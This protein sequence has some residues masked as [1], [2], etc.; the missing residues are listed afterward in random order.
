MDYGNWTAEVSG[1][2]LWVKSGQVPAE[3]RDATDISPVRVRNSTSN[4]E[5]GIIVGQ[6]RR[7]APFL[8]HDHRWIPYGG[9]TRVMRLDRKALVDAL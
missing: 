6:L 5:L 2:G 8:T 7:N 1:H 4:W 9:I 3:A